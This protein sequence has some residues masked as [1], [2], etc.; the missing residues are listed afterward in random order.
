MKPKPHLR[1]WGARPSAGGRAKVRGPCGA[2]PG[3]MWRVVPSE[4]RGL[5]ARTVRPDEWQGI[6][7]PPVPFREAGGQEGA[8]LGLASCHPRGRAEPAPPGGQSKARWPYGGKPGSGAKVGSLGGTRSPRPHCKAVRKPRHSKII[9]AKRIPGG[10]MGTCPGEAN[11]VVAGVQSPPLRY[12]N[13][14][15]RTRGPKR[16]IR[17]DPQSRHAEREEPAPRQ[18]FSR[19]EPRDP[20]SPR[21]EGLDSGKPRPL[22]SPINCPKGQKPVRVKGFREKI[23][24]VVR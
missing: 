11:S 2:N 19:F 12:P 20:I 5:R 15:A 14:L 22:Y 6:A 23:Q 17:C 10:Q 7:L 1:A 3:I 9:G 21:V 13:G 18:S 24:E 16:G 4:G 8:M